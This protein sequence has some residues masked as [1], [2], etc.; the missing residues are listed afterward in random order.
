[1]G[2]DLARRRGLDLARCRAA[3]TR[4]RGR[5]PR[6]R[7]SP[8]GRGAAPARPPRRARPRV[9][10]RLIPTLEPSREGFTQSGRPELGAALAPALLPDR[11]E[12]DLGEAARR[13]RAASAS[14]CPCRSPRRGR[15]SRRRGGRATRAGPGRCRPRRRARAGRGRRRRRRAGPRPGVSVDRLPVAGPGAVAGDRHPQRLVARRLEARARPPRRS[16]ARRRARRSGRRRGPRPSF[17][18]FFFG[19]GAAAR[20]PTTMVTVEPGST[21]EPRRRELVGD[22]ADLRGD[23]GLLFLHRRLQAGFAERSRRLRRAPCRSR[24]G[25]SPFLRPSR[26][27]SRR[28]S[29]A[30]PG[31]RRSA[32]GGS[33]ARRRRALASSVTLGTRP[34]PRICWTATERWVP[35]RTG[36][37][38]S[39]GPVETVR[40][41]G[42]ASVA[43][44]PPDGSEWITSPASTLRS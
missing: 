37:F 12:L 21:S 42:R 3:S 27:R 33:P 41:D 19:R 18:G 26:R 44:V 34:R 11:D 25:P 23:F 9:S 24:S 29:R 13:R 43:V 10:T 8:A 39:F 28:S 6:P 31:C 30:A 14:A 2:D 4:P 16:A 15:R 38:A 1:M 17:F 22:A 32:P 5:G 36:T 7:R 20:L 35:T 40:V